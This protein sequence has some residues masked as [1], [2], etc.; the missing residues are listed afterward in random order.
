VFS[1]FTDIYCGVPELAEI[2]QALRV[3]PKK[4]GDEYRYQYG[5]EDPSDRCYR[6]FVF[7]TYTVGPTE[8]CALQ[9]IM[10]T[11]HKEPEE[12]IC[13]FSIQAEPA[14]INLLG[15][16]L[17]EFGECKHLE[18]RWSPTEVELFEEYQD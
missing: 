13:K 15:E 4:I 16:A 3:F 9:I 1:G 5:S 17:K 8:H 14:S 7:R 6:Y 11:N 18:L 2:G 12:G 10:N